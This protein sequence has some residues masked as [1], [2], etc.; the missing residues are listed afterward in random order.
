ME[1]FLKGKL[2]YK[3]EN[4]KKVYAIKIPFGNEKNGEVI[5]KD[6]FI[7][8]TKND[9]NNKEKYTYT[10][11]CK[12]GK[13]RPIIAENDYFKLELENNTTLNLGFDNDKALFSHNNKSEDLIVINYKKDKVK[14]FI[15]YLN[16]NK[17][18]IVEYR[19]FDDNKPEIK[20]HFKKEQ[21]EYVIQDLQIFKDDKILISSTFKNDIEYRKEY[22]KDGSLKYLTKLDVV[23][24]DDL[25]QNETI[26]TEIYLQSPL[27]SE[28]KVQKNLI[29][30][31]D[32]ATQETTT[33][34]L[35]DNQS[36][37]LEIEPNDNQSQN[38]AA[39]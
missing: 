9:S 14:S 15:Y 31:K 20:R 19:K 4:G 33:L 13:K 28:I 37:V 17:N 39:A 18:D 34:Y 30:F 23:D 10:L 5:Y 35:S 11:L 12:D 26:S 3:K 32:L 22:R 6:Y 2:L 27:E 8:K 21:D 7:T 25:S 36:K 38:R 1:S 16:E 29:R 24:L